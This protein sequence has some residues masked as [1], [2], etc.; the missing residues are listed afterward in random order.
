MGTFCS[1]IMH[2][3]NAGNARDVRV[4]CK[5]RTCACTQARVLQFLH[6][7]AREEISG[8]MKVKGGNGRINHL[9]HIG[10]CNAKCIVAGTIVW[11][12]CV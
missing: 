10:M 11:Q 12:T 4:F 9:V 8:R 5:M 7:L 3:R 2:A 1:I 6:R